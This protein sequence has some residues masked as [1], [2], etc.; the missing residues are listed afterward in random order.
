MLPR[1]SV[2]CPLYNEQE[3]IPTFLSKIS[4][5]FE[6]RGISYE[7]VCVNDGSTD[8]TLQL[9]IE[10]KAEYTSLRILNLSRNFGKEAALSA[11]LSAARGDAIIPIDA[12]LQDPPEVIP[13][14]IAEWEKGFDIVLARRVDRSSD[15]AAKRLSASMFYKFHNLISKHQIPDN[16]GDFRLITRRVAAEIVKL[17]ENQRFMKGLFSWVGFESTTIDYERAQRYAGKTT[18]NAWSLW[19]F[20]LDGLTSFSTAP[21]RLWLYLG[22]ILSLMAFLMGIYIVFVTLFY[23]IDVPG[24]AS[25]VTVVLFFGGVQLFSIGVLGEYIGRIYLESKQRPSYIVENEY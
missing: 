24:Y 17:P 15:H 9:L 14:L 10:K 1:V 6:S 8:N 18:F 4:A 3:N 13:K 5:V 11:G 23:G 20:A 25:I 21:L 12:D 2:I 16:V 7:I 22:F 19:N